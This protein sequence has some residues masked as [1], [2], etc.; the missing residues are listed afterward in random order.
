MNEQIAKKVAEM[1]SELVA[2]RRDI[3]RHAE[4]AWLEFRTASLVVKKLQA[5][6]FAVSYGP[7]VIKEEAMMGVPAPEVVAKAQQRALEQGADPEIVKAMAGGKTGVVATFDSGKPGP[8]VG[9]RFDMDANDLTEAQDVKHRPFREG[10]ASINAGAMHGCGHDAHTSIG[11]G[12]AAVISQIKDELRGK[13]KLVFQ[14]AEE[15]ARGAKSMAEAGV[16]DDVDY[17]I[18]IHV[19]LS[20]QKV[21]QVVCG[22]GAE[23]FPASTKLD[24]TFSGASAHAGGAPETG[25]NTIL[26]ATAAI[27]NLYAISRHSKG[28]TRVNV[29]T[30]QGGSG[31]NVIPAYVHLRLETRGADWE[32]NEYMRERAYQIIA[33]AADMYG[34]DFTTTLMGE[35]IGGV[36]SRPLAEK[37]AEIAQ[38]IPEITEPEALGPFAY[39]GSEDYTYFMDRVQQLG[40]Q[41]TCIVLGT[42]LSAVHHNPYFDINEDVLPLGVK[43]L[44]ESALKLTTTMPTIR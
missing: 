7:E 34:V 29:G 44:G 19:G 43:L 1:E 11:L 26:A 41:A 20:R 16:V 12:L 10:F 30:I 22:A 38:T 9:F 6:G 21:G 13:V 42:E 27:Q 33:G 18:G 39:G 3:H 28:L 23:G 31:R 25:R 15:G 4:T 32:L 2:I 8:V 14:S 5:L 37:I 24:V 36:P 40:G 35:I 17:M